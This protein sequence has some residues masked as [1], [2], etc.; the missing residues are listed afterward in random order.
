MRPL[1][2]IE[3]R[4]KSKT[5]RDKMWRLLSEEAKSDP[6]LIVAENHEKELIVKGVSTLQ[7]EILVD[8]LRRQAGIRFSV[9]KPRVIYLQPIMRV[10]L[11]VPV[12]LQ[13]LFLKDLAR[14]GG[15][16]AQTSPKIEA[17]VPLAALI[18]YADYLGSQSRK[19][20]RCEVSVVF[21][22][23]EEMLAP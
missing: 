8:R 14:R 23:D 4:L 22:Y 9:S 6:D 17:L 15:R 5:D 10:E 11:T 12:N 3:V 19:N 13:S 2:A 7:L 21:A 16:V 18:G 20:G 1:L